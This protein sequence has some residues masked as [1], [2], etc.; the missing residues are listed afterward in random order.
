MQVD[1]IIAGAGLGGCAAAMSACA[2]GLTVLLTEETEWIGGQV[3]SQGVPP[4]EHQWIEEFGCTKRYRMYRNKVRETYKRAMN[5]KN[6]CAQFNPGNGLVSNI[7]HD[8]RVTLHVLQEMLMPYVL[9][10]Q[11]TISLN[12]AVTKAEK[13]DRKISSITIKN[14]KT[15]K[16]TDAFAP[17]YIDATESGE[18]LPLAGIEYVT[19]AESKADTG[20]PH[21]L[22]VPNPSDIQAFTYVLGMEYRSGEDHTIEKPEMY[23]FWKEFR[24]IFWPDKF[25]SFYAPHPIT[26]KKRKYTLFREETGF[27]LW[28]Y[29]RALDIEQY[30]LSYDAGEVTLL[31]W[32]QNDYFLGNVYDVSD[33]DREKHLFEA[34]QLSLSLLYWLQTEATRPDGGKG[35]PGIKL[36]KDIFNTEDGLAKAPYLRESRRIKAEYTILEQDVSPDFNN[37]KTGKKYKDS[38]G[39]GSYSID[40][41]PSMAGRN[42]LDI[43]ALP[44]HISLGALIPKD[45][46]NVLAGCKNIGSTHITN[47]CY[48]LHPVE[49]NVGEA[50]GALVAFCIEKQT[51]PKV[52]R[53]NSELLHLFQKDLRNDGFELEWPEE[54]YL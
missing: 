19:G 27:P 24:P 14:L 16:F 44:F 36:R 42:Y 52:V 13:D 8:P 41:H 33:A 34:K 5:I 22:E 18:L 11:L 1:L 53:N 46:E 48:R 31:N 38:V 17:Y 28:E 3:T 47:G 26:K 6:D 51:E 32:P 40:L 54:F 9:T 49:W 4:D 23:D 30:N 25:L 45:M 39:I 10:N 2:N 50:C 37:G 7:C 35:Y 20:E 43:K 21:A 29:R 12:S 15:G